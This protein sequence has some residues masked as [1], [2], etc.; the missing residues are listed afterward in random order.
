MSE[1]KLALQLITA[2]NGFIV[3]VKPD[4]RESLEERFWGVKSPLHQKLL[5]KLFFCFKFN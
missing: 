2:Y 1:I 4:I 5:S 3:W